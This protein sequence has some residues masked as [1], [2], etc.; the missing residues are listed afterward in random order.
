M[1]KVC[2]DQC[3]ISKMAI[4]KTED[5]AFQEL[6]RIM[7]E[8]SDRN[9]IVCPIAPETI[10]ETTC[11]PSE[12]RIRVHELHSYLAGARH[13][14]PCW[15]F[16][17]M[18]NLINEET[19]SMA[20]CE[21]PPAAFDLIHWRRVEDDQLAFKRASDLKNGKRQMA[22]RMQ[23]AQFAPIR[24]CDELNAM[25]PSVL[26]EHVS[27]VL[28]Q[29]NRLLND[30]VLVPED[31]MGYELAKYLKKHGIQKN[32]LEKLSTEIVNHRWECI[33]VIF[34][35]TQLV[36][37]LEKE[38]SRVNSPR[39]YKVNDELDIPRIAVGLVSSDVII[40]DGPMAALCNQGKTQ[41]WARAKVFSVQEAEKAI[42]HLEIELSRTQH[43]K[44]TVEPLG[45]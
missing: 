8:G 4:S 10:A 36:N 32:E 35:R 16:K 23:S 5:S 39:K 27:H 19:L 17:S 34:S 37:Q 26:L 14:S 6:K 28:R 30:E 7:I 21:P 9:S 31:H 18:W 45:D 24:K 15:A 1:I 25:G 13:G 42:A 38:F 11:L 40:T 2:L 22:D 29:I 44:K 33:P 3:A 43:G 20:R 41:K 12:C